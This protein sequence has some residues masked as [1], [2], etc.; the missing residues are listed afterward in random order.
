[1]VVDLCHQACPPLKLTYS[2]QQPK[3]QP[4]NPLISFKIKSQL[5]RCWLGNLWVM[6][7]LDTLCFGF[8]DSRFHYCGW[9]SEWVRSWKVPSF[10]WLVVFGC[11]KKDR[12]LGEAQVTPRSA[13]TPPNPWLI[14]R[15]PNPQLDFSL[16]HSLIDYL[17]LTLFC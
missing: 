13:T 16:P 3:P 10:P 5:I 2:P 4:I 8:D 15:N 17:Y 14:Y 1:V 11:A 12:E 9:D 6:S 7:N